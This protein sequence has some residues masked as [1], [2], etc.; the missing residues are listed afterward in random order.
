M[1]TAATL[2]RLLPLTIQEFPDKTRGKVIEIYSSAF[3]HDDIARKSCK[4]F[5][6]GGCAAAQ[7]YFQGSANLVRRGN[8]SREALT[9][10]ADHLFHKA[11]KEYGFDEK[12]GFL[13]PSSG[14]KIPYAERS[15]ICVS[16]SCE[17]MTVDQ[18]ELA[19]SLDSKFTGERR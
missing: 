1:T 12:L 13:D 19:N 2:P 7:G 17:K 14:C 10:Q 16:Y 6:C 18:R 3:L 9:N 8:I 5:C 15:F 11:K 4:G